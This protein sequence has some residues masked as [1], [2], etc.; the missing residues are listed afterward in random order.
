VFHQH[1]LHGGLQI[2]PA[3]ENLPA[4]FGVQTQGIQEG[5]LAPVEQVVAGQLHEIDPYVLEQGDVRG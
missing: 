4:A 5:G 2:G 3:P 1:R